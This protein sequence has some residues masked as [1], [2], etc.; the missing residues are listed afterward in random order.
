MKIKISLVLVVCL[1][2]LIGCRP[3]KKLNERLVAMEGKMDQYHQEE[4]TALQKNHQEAMAAITALNEAISKNSRNVEELG[5]KLDIL[6]QKGVEVSGQMYAHTTVHVREGPS[7]K[8]KSVGYLK[9]GEVVKIDRIERKWVRI[10][11]GQWQGKWCTML[12]M[13][14]SVEPIAESQ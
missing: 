4:M 9:G 8:F 10:K 7:M 11:E 3:F 14:L 12:Y 1:S 6:I 2:L 5:K 13:Q